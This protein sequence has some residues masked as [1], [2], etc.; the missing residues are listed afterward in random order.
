MVKKLFESKK[1]AFWQ[2]FFLTVLFFLIGFVLGVYV[3]QLRADSINSEFYYSETSLYDSFALGQV[4]QDSF[5]PCDIL[6]KEISGFADRIY[7]EAQQLERYDSAN[8][9]TQSVKT[10]H[11]K[12][13]LL[14]TILWINI[15]DMKEKTEDCSLNTVVYLYVYDTQDVDIRAKQ[16]AW[17][18]VLSDLKEEE[19]SEIVL[20]PIASDQNINSLDYLM[21]KY[22]IT[23][24]PAVIVNE[25]HVFYDLKTKRELKN[26]LE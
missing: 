11:R 1:H 26:F 6:K 17:G 25:E 16:T 8:Q 24:S 10:I 18:R 4:L 14:R 2:A 21:W 9:L 7:N 15:I 3:E 12:Y 22:N 5:A 20:I 19:G 23:E 13:D